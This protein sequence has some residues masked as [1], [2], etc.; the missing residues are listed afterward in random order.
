MMKN[1]NHFIEIALLVIISFISLSNTSN[2][3]NFELDPSLC[4]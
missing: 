4:R 2:L 3:G 1:G